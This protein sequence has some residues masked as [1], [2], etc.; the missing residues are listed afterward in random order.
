MSK[1]NKNARTRGVGPAPAGAIHRMKLEIMD[2]RTKLVQLGAGIAP[3]MDAA[4]AA[5]NSMEA[6]I[7]S[8]TAA[9]EAAYRIIED[10]RGRET[11]LLA[12][13]AMSMDGTIDSAL[14]ETLRARITA[15]FASIE[16]S[17]NPE[18]PGVHA[19]EKGAAPPLPEIIVA[20]LAEEADAAMTSCNDPST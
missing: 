19:D 9:L 13:C 5:V 12:E 14:A 20:A 4:E 7:A 17:G 6:Q 10:R 11:S 2:A 1:K 16:H 18:M 15:F 3:Y 8:L